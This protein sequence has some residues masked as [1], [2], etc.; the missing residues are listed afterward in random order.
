MTPGT[1]L[2]LINTTDKKLIICSLIGNK[3]I[4][5]RLTSFYYEL[6]DKVSSMNPKPHVIFPPNIPNPEEYLKHT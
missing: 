3:N 5:K 2:Y 6:V 4:N 1:V